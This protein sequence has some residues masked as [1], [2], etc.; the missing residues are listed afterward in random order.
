MHRANKF[1]VFLL[2]LLFSWLGL[3]V[4]PLIS[5]GMVW[6]ET[7]RLTQKA[8]RL[9][10]EF[11]NPMPK[12]DL[13]ARKF[14]RE[15]WKFGIVSPDGRTF[16]PPAAREASALF[17]YNFASQT[18]SAKSQNKPMSNVHEDTVRSAA[19][20]SRFA[21]RPTPDEDVILKITSR[22]QGEFYGSAGAAFQL[23]NT[24]RQDGSLSK[25]ID[26][27]GVAVV[28]GETSAS[29]SV[30]FVTLG[31]IP[32]QVKEM[33]ADARLRHEYVIRLNWINRTEWRGT[34]LVDGK[35]ICSLP[36]PPLGAVEARVWRDSFT[37][38]IGW[39][40]RWWEIGPFVKPHM[41][42]GRFA[43][44]SIQVYTE[45]R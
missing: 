36:L 14:S 20:I 27:F 23:E 16:Q 5:K 32:L 24:F 10:I 25:P 11:Q 43:I 30:C 21:F 41:G 39:P 44:E 40:R 38:P 45:A 26:M 18:P 13:F 19:L 8:L 35:N 31:G 1:I 42:A 17:K 4:R 12:Q 29:G 3:S 34:V 28:G 7:T 33:E 22:V 6:L 15:F 2:V 37:S 9:P